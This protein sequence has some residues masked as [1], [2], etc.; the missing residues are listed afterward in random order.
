MNTRICFEPLE[1]RLLLS[2]SWGTGADTPGPDE[3]GSNT[4]ATVLPQSIA[5]ASRIQSDHQ[6]ND[7]TI[8]AVDLL[9]QAPH[10]N[11]S[12]SA[13]SAHANENNGT[14][15]TE[16]RPEIREQEESRELI[17][18][19]GKVAGYRKL[20]T[21]LQT[22]PNSRQF[23]VVVLDGNSDGIAQVSEILGGYSDL[24]AVHFITH[25]TE[26]QINIGNTYLNTTLLQQNSDA[27]AG[28]GNAL[29]KTGD[30]LFY[31]CNIA[32]GNHGLFLLNHIADLTGA[33]VA[34]SDDATGHASKGGDWDLEYSAGMV[35]TRT[36]IQPGA[37]N[38]WAHLLVPPVITSNGGGPTANINVVENTTAVTT[39]TA[40]DADPGDVPTFSISGGADA[41]LF[42]IDTNSGDLTFKT[43][44]DF[45]NPTD[46]NTDNLYEVEVTADDGNGGMDTQT[47]SV[48]V[49]NADNGIWITP[50]QDSGTGADGIAGWREGE[51]LQLGGPDL[52]L[53]PATDGDFSSVIDFDPFIDFAFSGTCDPGALHF[54]TRDL[55]VGSGANQFNL[56]IGDVLVSFNQN[57]TILAAYSATGSDLGAGMNDLLVF[58]P[59][60]LGDFTSGTFSMLLN[61]VPYPG[62]GAI[63][64][65]NAISLVEQD[66]YVGN[67]LLPSGSFLF[68][69][70]TGSGPN[71]PNHIY[72]FTPTDVGSVAAAG[73]SQILIDGGDIGIETATS[74]YIRGL[75][76]IE[77]PTTVGGLALDEGDILVTLNQDDG[78]V[79]DAPT[80]ATSTSDVFVLKVTRSEPEPGNLT[81][82]TAEM[83]MDGSDVNF[84]G[85]ERV[86]AISLVP[87]NF[88]P[89]VGGDDTGA[90][91]EDVGVAGGNISD[92]GTLTVTDPDAGESSFVAETIMG[93][94][95]SLDIDGTGNWTYTADN[96]QAA[97]QGLNTGDNLTDLFLVTT[98][99][100]T[101]QRVTITI[102]GADE[103]ANTPP[104]AADDPGDFA[105]TV[106]AHTPL[107]YW[108]L[109]EAA[110]SAADLGSSANS[111][112][113]NVA[114]LGQSG[115]INGDSDTAVQFDALTTD[116]VAIAH[117]DD[118]LLNN[119]TVQL[120][121]NVDI[122]ATGDLQHLLSK[123]SQGND[124]GGHL[125]IYLDAAGRLEVRL[126]STSDSYFV[127]TSSAV[128]EGQWHH[129]AFTFG[130][131][132]MVLYL[133]GQS[134][135]TN[136][137]TGGM[138]T[139]SGG[140]GNHEPIA[141][142]GGTQLSDDL[143]ITPV[144][145]F[146]TGLIDEVA[147]VGSQLDGEAIRELFG[148][149]RQDYTVDED[150]TLNVS[151]VEG[152]LINDF[153]ADTDPLTVT[154][155]NGSAANIGVPVILGSGTQVTLNADGSFIYDPNGQFEHLGMGQTA[156][157]T[158]TYIANDGTSD[159]NPATVS[160]T[161]TGVNDTPVAFAD[162]FTVNEGSTTTLDLAD[163]DSDA[164]D[165]LDL[166]SIA[167]VSG[168]T[169]GTIVINGNG[170]V[171]YIHDDTENF[172]D[173]FSYTINDNSGVTSNTGTVTITIT[174]QN[175]N[176]PVADDESFTVTEGGTATEANL[177][178]GTSLLDGDTDIDL[179]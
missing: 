166:T 56:Q 146:F 49:T 72:H 22:D 64:N 129:V 164:D 152:V 90:V 100:G 150:S 118:Y 60:T 89:A 41:A 84:S 147:I 151:A 62:G 109:G 73:I 34:A 65:L 79:G 103:L 139:S 91:T 107:S 61:G 124:T 96:S 80:L 170:T 171:D 101:T 75:D 172:A 102:N 105:A 21:D 71:T 4:K 135:D 131:G 5:E 32:A 19:D 110:G 108:R 148:A 98:A 176:N 163:N 83:V 59:D 81:A 39:V 15:T 70:Q 46:S 28:W 161:V 25:G 169:Y 27:V 8:G 173:S 116:Y 104:V 177:N 67:T 57:E 37:Q 68:S 167:I 134:V 14:A 144:D 143:L 86:Y 55:T 51:V 125:S 106:L 30:I 154:E 31:G 121:F 162:S 130:A 123:D 66:T 145:Q 16:N 111:G 24:T 6:S 113:Y 179:P 153:D 88:G 33:D 38:S 114:G 112:T 115:A 122:A 174:P 157:D 50:D 159:S 11:P 26:G 178:A 23:E 168:P 165:G 45:E 142:G 2:G 78:F 63:S 58:R 132:G 155:I 40:T 52:T 156:T 126:Q 18:I 120:W 43:H 127:N 13:V 93:T 141:I 76:L 1:P 92:A 137:Y 136:V 85:T 9:A 20:I 54:V 42:D 175:D 82:A 36:A 3:Q 95:G 53:G 133:D 128:T 17:I 10:F 7:Q 140:T 94:H 77:K 149:A 87:D 74:S 138:G 99:D 160:I 97:I 44:P 117:S 48:T 69:E 12:D 29:T 35:E 119:G 158:F 47:I